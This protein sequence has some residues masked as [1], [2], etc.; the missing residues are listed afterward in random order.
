MNVSK[1]S[2][3]TEVLIANRDQDICIVKLD[4]TTLAVAR[5]LAREFG[6]PVTIRDP[7][8]DSVIKVVRP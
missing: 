4:Q 6:A 7:I 2:K 1:S 3:Q 5:D 8:T